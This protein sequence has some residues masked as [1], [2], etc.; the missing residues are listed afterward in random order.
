M[1]I[2]Q[3]SQSMIVRRD[4]FGA[5]SRFT[6][7][8]SMVASGK[9]LASASDDPLDAATAMRHRRTIRH[10][11]QFERNASD[12]ELW[13]NAAD[14]AL[15]AVDDRISQ[16][17]VLAVQAGNGALGSDALSAVSTQLRGLASELVGIAN[18]TRLGRP[19]F[20]GTA[21][22]SE[23]YSASGLYLGDSGEVERSISTG[24]DLVVNLNGES[25]FGVSNPGQPAGGNLFELLN[26]IADEIDAG[27]PITC[28]LADIDAAQSR[29]HQNQASVGSSRNT[30]IRA[31]DHNSLETVDV[32]ASLSKVEDVDL[33]EAILDLR[34]QEAAYQAAL[35]VTGRV[36]GQSL[37]DYL[38]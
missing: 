25:I 2:T 37:L 22:G 12:A 6:R 19:I 35:G 15:V 27:N 9:R 5:Q 33:A 36:L 20:G 16:A 8:Q 26:H 1:R 14:S 38:R 3:Q 34:S 30:L 23:A 28:R 32:T 17:R 10:L 13:L 29:V 7:S 11:D 21:G 4:V 18:T 24:E 31:M